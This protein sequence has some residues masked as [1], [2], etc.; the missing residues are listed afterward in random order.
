MGKSGAE[1]GSFW[2]FLSVVL[3]IYVIACAMGVYVLPD[4]CFPLHPRRG[5]APAWPAFLTF[6]LS[7][8]LSPIL[9]RWKPRVF[10]LPDGLSFCLVKKKQK[11]DLWAAPLRTRLLEM[12][13]VKG[14]GQGKV[15]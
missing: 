4:G 15:R 14:K 9:A 5:R 8:R 13:K 11:Y 6:V 12:V 3:L 7:V 10:V 1:D 2:G